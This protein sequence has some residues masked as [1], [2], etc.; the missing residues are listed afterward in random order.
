[1]GMGEQRHTAVALPQGK[2]SGTHFIGGLVGPSSCLECCG[3]LQLPPRFDPVNVQPVS[4]SL[5]SLQF[6]GS[7]SNVYLTRRTRSTI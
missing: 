3:K 6:P 5:C 7:G 1:M 4:G 2:R